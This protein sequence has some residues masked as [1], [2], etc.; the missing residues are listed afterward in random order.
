MAD[1]YSW[2]TNDP[3]IAAKL[4]DIDT[5]WTTARQSASRF[6]LKEKLAGYK[7]ADEVRATALRDLLAS[8]GINVILRNPN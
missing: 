4:R 6:A 1:D 7:V 8:C 2:I 3:E 5:A